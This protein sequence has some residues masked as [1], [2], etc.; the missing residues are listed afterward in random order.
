MCMLYLNITADRVMHLLWCCDVIV[1]MEYVYNKRT[2]AMK[3]IAVNIYGK[4]HLVHYKL[5][6]SHI[7]VWK[8]SNIEKV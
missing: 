6:Y 3:G 1:T 8:T 5:L 4:V 7:L 2:S